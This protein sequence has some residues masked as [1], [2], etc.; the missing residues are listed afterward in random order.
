MNVELEGPS[1]VP[2]KCHSIVGHGSDTTSTENMTVLPLVLTISA[3][4]SRSSVAPSSLK[5]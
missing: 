2:L 1:C 3:P 4:T 5:L